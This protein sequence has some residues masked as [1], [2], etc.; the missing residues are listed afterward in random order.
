[1][2]DDY[3]VI[4]NIFK[5]K[6]VQKFVLIALVVTIVSLVALSSIEAKSTTFCY[7]IACKIEGAGDRCTG[8]SAYHSDDSCPN[9]V[10]WHDYCCN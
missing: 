8:E 6:M 3:G 10:P 7:W 4:L 1:M 5:L 2:Q 9:G